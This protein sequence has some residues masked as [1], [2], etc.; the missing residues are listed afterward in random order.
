V[1]LGLRLLVFLDL[2]RDLAIRVPILDGRWNL[3]AARRLLEEGWGPEPF[4]MAPLYPHLLAP[5]ARLADAVTAARLLN[6]ILGM[7][8]WLLA[9]RLAR[10]LAGLRAAAATGWILALS[11]PVLF[12]ENLLTVD[13]LLS[14]LVLLF[15]ELASR[16]G[17]ERPARAFLVGMVAALAALCR[18]SYLLLVLVPVAAAGRGLRL[19]TAGLLAAGWI[20]VLLGPALHNARTGAPWALVS[21]NGGLNLYL[22]FH[23]G[24]RGGYHAPPELAYPQD[25]TGRQAASRLAGRELDAMASSRFWARRAWDWIREHPA[26]ALLL[27]LRKLGLWLGAREEPQI[28]VFQEIRSRHPSLWLAPLSFAWLLALAGVGWVFGRDDLR[29][30]R[31]ARV[32]WGSLAVVLLTALVTFSVGRFRLP[33]WWLLGIPAG[34]GAVAILGRLR[35]RRRWA[36]LLLLGGIL[37]ASH[38]MPQ[39]S[40]RRARAHHYHALALRYLER[41]QDE[42][43]LAQIQ[44][45]LRRD[46]G[47]TPAYRTAGEILMRQGRLREALAAFETALRSDRDPRLLHNAGTVAGRLGD[48][49]LALRYLEEAAKARPGDPAILTDLGVA[50]WYAGRPEEARRY[51]RRALERDPSYEAARRYL[52][53]G[54]PEAGRNP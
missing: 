1:A 39:P 42:E 11:G 26:E 3:E 7:V 49:Q 47:F 10:R 36:P 50:L 35:G 15:V 54:A 48:H 14:V 53:E 41:G 18:A 29:C 8:A 46:P 31:F 45:A 37:L 52:E 28:E 17:L 51:W 9:V 33:A 40:L 4:F 30:P 25:P 24:S 2:G 38:L 43:A 16:D 5:V 20:L 12:Y 34:V 23:E 21:T 19:R 13:A 27:E 6:L 32:W 22:G 44:R